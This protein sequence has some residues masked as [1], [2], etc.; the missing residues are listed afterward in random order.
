MENKEVFGLP[1]KYEKW[2]KQEELPLYISN[3]Y[4]FKTAYIDKLRCIII[5][6]KNEIDTILALKKHIEQIKIVDN[7]QIILQIEKVSYYRRKSLIEN[8]ISFISNKQ[9]YL[10][11]IGALFV[12]EK[13]DKLDKLDKFTVSTQMLFLAYWYS[14][15]R[16]IYVSEISK[17][18][19]FSAMTISRAVKQLNTTKLFIITKDGVN[20]I[21]E[22]KY[23]WGTLLEKIKIYLSSPI[24]KI[25]YIEKNNVKE[26][27]VIAGES[28]LSE[29]T[30]LSEPRIKTYAIYHKKIDNV[31]IQ[32]ELINPKEQVRLEIWD[33][34]PTKFSNGNMVDN[35]S[36]FL[37]FNNNK[38]ERIEESLE[39]MMKVEL[40]K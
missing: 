30:M 16:K 14:R 38:D 1:I 34:E 7:C 8:K 5:S 2:N 15:K 37:S 20:N 21:I 35:I 23:D 27:M 26:N 4:E 33:Y 9:L 18:L 32:N 24:K 13:E 19:E 3:R 10:P 17:Q 22:S 36:L 12:N 40:N 31:E 25:G 28:A 6:P 11:F 29:M 39:E